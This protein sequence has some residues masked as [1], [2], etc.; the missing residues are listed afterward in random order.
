MKI[1]NILIIRADKAIESLIALK[2]PLKVKT[3][4]KLS[5]LSLAI[6][7]EASALEMTKNQILGKF[8]SE[9]EDLTPNHPNFKLF[10]NEWREVADLETE[11]SIEKIKLEELDVEGAII[12]IDILRDLDSFIEQ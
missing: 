8:I 6:R 3:N 5:K 9:G 4:Y 11:I 12:P 7:S 2:L 10:F 1:K